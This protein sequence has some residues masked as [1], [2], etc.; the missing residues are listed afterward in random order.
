[1][2]LLRTE[3]RAADSGCLHSGLIEKLVAAGESVKGVP[4]LLGS[5]SWYLRLQALSAGICLSWSETVRPDV[6]EYARLAF[7]IS[8]NVR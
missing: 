8:V 6:L 1:M 4:L 3:R 2:R 5:C 7:S